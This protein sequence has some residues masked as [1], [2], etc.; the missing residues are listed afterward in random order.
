MVDP[1]DSALLYNE[2]LFQFYAAN[3][4][5]NIYL[6]KM[7]AIFSNIFLGKIAAIFS[8]NIYLA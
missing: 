3:I 4:S 6:H 2:L 5:D 1:I 7:A 8:D